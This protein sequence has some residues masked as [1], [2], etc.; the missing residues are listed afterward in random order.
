MPNWMFNQFFDYR[1]ILAK[2]LLSYRQP[3]R[4][5]CALVLT[6][7]YHR[8]NQG[9]RLRLPKRKVPTLTVDEDLTEIKD[10]KNKDKE[11]KY[12][13]VF[14]LKLPIGRNFKFAVAESFQ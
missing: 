11:K 6:Q 1:K 7:T 9:Q 12:S 2:L 14:T 5:Q 8:L 4:N 10:K 3:A 13:F